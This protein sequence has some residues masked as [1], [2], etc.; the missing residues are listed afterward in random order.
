MAKLHKNMKENNNLTEDQQ[1]LDIT[2]LF[3]NLVTLAGL[4]LG[5]SAIKFALAGKFEH[6]VTFIII[7]T[8][9][10]AFDGR[11][12][13][14][15]NATSKFGGE[16]DSLCD[17]INFGFTP[18]FV[19]Y[20]WSL[21]NLPAFGWAGVLFF[22]ICTAIRLARFNSD[23]DTTKADKPEWAQK[24]F[25]GI[26]SPAGALLCLAPL[27]VSFVLEDKFTK[28][29]NAWQFVMQPY[30]ILVWSM[31]VALLMASRLPTYSFKK[32]LIRRKLISIFLVFISLCMVLASIEPWLMVLFTGVLYVVSIFIST[33]HYLKLT[34]KN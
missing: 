9:V 27:M 15:L 2:K 28:S 33:A 29:A 1:H 6:A 30:F 8:F 17:F 32:V 23:I 26:P 19:I 34:A 18:S 5:V 10:D 12:A 22:T 20:L 16:L 3:P 4:C 13:R 14:A 7:A 25:T 11:L 24:F 31:F 21:H